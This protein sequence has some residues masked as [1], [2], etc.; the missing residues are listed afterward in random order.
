MIAVTC[1]GL[2]PAD[3]TNKQLGLFGDQLAKEQII[4]SAVDEINARYGSRT[5]HSA[6]T[7]GTAMVKTKIPFGST[8]YL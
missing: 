5:I 6:D 7:L 2:E 3:D 1:Y 8:R 4:T